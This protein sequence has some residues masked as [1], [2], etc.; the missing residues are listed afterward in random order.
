MVKASKAVRNT[1][2][3]G[4]WLALFSCFPTSASA[5]ATDTASDVLKQS[6]SPKPIGLVNSSNGGV[7]QKGDYGIILKYITYDQDELFNGTDAIDYTRPAKGEKPSK[8]VNKKSYQRFQ[9]TF[10]TG[11]TENMDARII[12][13]LF[14]KELNRQSCNMDF[15]DDNSG[16]GDIK[17]LTR[18]RFLSQK[19]HDPLNLAFG[20]GLKIPTGNT[21]ETDANGATPAYLQPG[22]GSWDPVI[23]IGAH[24]IIQSHWLSTY[25]M[26]KMSTE[27]EVGD[28]DYEKPDIFKYNFGYAY[29][30]SKILDFQIELNGEF[31]SKA[32][33]AGIE[34]EN[35]GGHILFITP[36]AHLKFYKKMHFDIGVAIPVYRDLNGMQVSEDYRVVTK[37]AL[38][39]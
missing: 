39:F 21:D 35:S 25:F 9:A 13:P 10:R 3:Y 23:E 11:I 4:L 15:S 14:N 18:Y 30:V 22:S 27:G 1:L 34:Q 31:K 24:K 29:A 12:V 17:V 38:K 20:I 32:K 37:L 33:L 2:I 19:L 8:K 6:S 36:G 16:I 28:Q 7:Y 26:Y 5:S